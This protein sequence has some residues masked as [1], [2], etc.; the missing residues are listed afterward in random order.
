LLSKRWTI[1]LF[2]EELGRSEVF[3]QGLDRL[4][5]LAILTI[6][7]AFGP[8]CL[9]FLA[10]LDVKSELT[11]TLDFI[12]TTALAEGDEEEPLAFDRR[13]RRMYSANAW[14]AFDTAIRDS[15]HPTAARI[16]IHARELIAEI[17]G[18]GEA[19]DSEGPP[20]LPVASF[21]R[22]SELG[23][24][25]LAVPDA[26]SPDLD[27]SADLDVFTSRF[28]S[29]L[30]RQL[31]MDEIL[32]EGFV[33]QI[34]HATVSNFSAVQAMLAADDPSYNAWLAVLTGEA[35]RT[36]VGT[37]FDRLHTQLA[38]LPE[39]W[40]AYKSGSIAERLMRTYHATL[41]RP[42]LDSAGRTDD[43]I[44]APIRG[45][46]YVPTAYR[47]TRAAELGS[48]P[49][50][51][52]GS[53]RSL[54]VNENLVGFLTSY[55]AALSSY[56]TPLLILGHAGAGKT[57]LVDV[58]SAAL[59]TERFCP[60]RIDLR[61]TSPDL[62]FA[63]IIEEAIR[64]RTGYRISWGEF[65]DGVS[66]RVPVLLLDG[67]DELLQNSGAAHSA[68][69]LRVQEFQLQQMD[70]GAPVKCVVTSRPNL[71]GHAAVPSDSAVVR[72]EPF[73]KQRVET[74]TAIWN[75]TNAAYFA[76]AG[77]EPFALPDD[78]VLLTFAALPLLLVM[79]ATFHG[80][81]NTLA[82][83]EG[84]NRSQIYWH[85][86][87]A[88]VR[89]EIEKTAVDRPPHVVLTSEAVES[90]VSEELHSLGLIALGMFRR[91][92]LAVSAEQIEEDLQF[93]APDDLHR[94]G[95]NRG[96]GDATA[97]R[98]SELLVGRF[99]FVQASESLLGGDTAVRQAVTYE[100]LHNTFR[101]FLA[102]LAL[103]RD[104]IRE[105]DDR[106]L[107]KK[108][109]PHNRLL[110]ESLADVDGLIERVGLLTTA[111]PLRA[112]PQVL[113]ML[114]EISPFLVEQ[115]EH[116]RAEVANT[117]GELLSLIASDLSKA[118]RANVHRDGSAMRLDLLAELTL[119]LLL[120]GNAISEHSFSV[121]L[122]RRDH[123]V[124]PWRRIL[125]VWRGEFS[126]LD[127]ALVPERLHVAEA[128]E[129]TTIFV[130]KGP[131]IWR[132]DVE[133]LDERWSAPLVVSLA[134]GDY[135]RQ[136]LYA[137]AARGGPSATTDAL[138]RIRFDAGLRT[139]LPT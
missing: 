34:Q 20:S 46:A 125:N 10:L 17:E 124:R 112:N 91:G 12:R 88:V 133:G 43:G 64:Q 28:L 97:L 57:L 104:V 109:S 111:V 137:T 54:P 5:G 15:T 95:T 129:P 3:I 96:V 53:W 99:L 14:T 60:I 126:P 127:L 48:S 107:S 136:Y 45:R 41:E 37:G 106:L 38:E 89:R 130:V 70:L 68:F 39:R 83:L 65:R 33:A 52:E 31:Q 120:I 67:Y 77:L 22:R 35:Q 27:T 110:A 113:D 4:L 76:A 102:G 84:Q 90:A 134:I 7:I 94:S 72:L 114:E 74:W 138:N 61:T 78:P 108:A 122:S 98:Q 86:I 24:L 81:G 75:E 55:L 59:A 47:V 56:E 93:L 13:M 63:T 131:H 82:S 58:L 44:V 30:A 40:I 80:E 1:A 73:D 26:T 100:F 115:H 119:N 25:P 18:A 62:D 21:F 105:C 42:I 2:L 128:D 23:R 135:E 69:L 116:S 51:S 29:L 92:R 117:I 101:E 19:V 49:I 103:I 8:Q 121:N 139:G 71:I 123:E 87:R 9:P 132:R 36:K 16:R 85:V 11:A 66:G 6:P 118:V 50:G 79:L 32:A